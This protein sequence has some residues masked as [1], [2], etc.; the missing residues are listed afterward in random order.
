MRVAIGDSPHEPQLGFTVAASNSA[1]DPSG[2]A[3]EVM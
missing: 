3:D 1:S 2:A